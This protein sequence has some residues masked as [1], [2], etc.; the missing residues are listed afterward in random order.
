MRYLLGNVYKTCN[1]P[2]KAQADFK[3]VAENSDFGDAMWAWK[4]SQQLLNFDP[5]VSKLKLQNVLERAKGDG[6]LN[7]PSGWWFYNAAMLD[8]V[9]GNSQQAE[10]EFWEALLSPD[11]LMTYHLTRLAISDS[12]L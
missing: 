5:G 8:A 12:T 11:L 2:D 3:Q 1:L 6:E 7:S 9:L 10:K 4:A